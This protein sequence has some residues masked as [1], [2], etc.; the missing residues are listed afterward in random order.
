MDKFPL[1]FKVMRGDIFYSP[2]D[3]D[4]V[5]VSRVGEDFLLLEINKMGEL[6]EIE[7]YD[8]I[9]LWMGKW[10]YIGKL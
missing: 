3:D 6:F 5:L 4:I 10:T 8:V 1:T 9:N 7:T 2:F